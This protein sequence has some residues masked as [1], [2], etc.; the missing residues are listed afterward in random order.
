MVLPAVM[1]YA[2]MIRED[3]RE[4][5]RLLLSFR[6]AL[7]AFERGDNFPLVLRNGDPFDV[8]RRSRRLTAR[9]RFA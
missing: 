5:L 2:V 7:A 4:D 1:H 8:A 6:I 3:E 9:T